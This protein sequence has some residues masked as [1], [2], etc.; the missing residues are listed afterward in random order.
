MR[1]NYLGIVLLCGLAF[2]GWAHSQT[3]SNPADF[4]TSPFVWDGTTCG[5]TQQLIYIA[6][7][8]YALNA[9]AVVYRVTDAYPVSKANRPWAVQLLPHIS[10][11]DFSI[12]VCTNHSGYT[13][14]NCSDGSDN[15]PGM[16][17]NVVV[18]GFYHGSHYIVV[19]GNINGTPQTCGAY[20]LTAIKH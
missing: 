8:G 15:G 3:W 13:L 17:N 18:P 5:F 12:W 14:S 9:P 10:Y 1:T 16:V 19:T 4:D 11:L 2:S 6:D 7:I 20:T